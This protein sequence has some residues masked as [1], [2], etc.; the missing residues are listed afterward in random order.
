MADLETTSVRKHK[1]AVSA[2]EPSVQ[3]TLAVIGGDTRSY[4]K[5]PGTTVQDMLKVLN[6]TGREARREGAILK[7]TYK[8]QN[9]DVLFLL[10]PAIEGGF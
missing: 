3:F 9:G 10:P 8:I 6:L 2:A 1:A 4:T 7:E 5:P